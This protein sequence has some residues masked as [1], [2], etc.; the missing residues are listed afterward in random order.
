[1]H[2][3]PLSFLALHQESIED[4]ALDVLHPVQQEILWEADKQITHLAALEAEPVQ[5][6]AH[7]EG[8]HGTHVHLKKVLHHFGYLGQVRRSD[9]L[10]LWLGGYLDL[11]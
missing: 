9:A 4:V 11:V 3:P 6:L 2:H 8:G 10:L 5:V 7:A 1:M